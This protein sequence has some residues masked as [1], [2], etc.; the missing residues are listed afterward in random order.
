MKA[1]VNAPKPPRVTWLVPESDDDVPDA[2]WFDESSL[3]KKLLREPMWLPP[4]EDPRDRHSAPVCSP[5]GAAM[6]GWFGAQFSRGIS[7]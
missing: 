5:G 6:P 3:L 4:P 7:A 2:E 1:C